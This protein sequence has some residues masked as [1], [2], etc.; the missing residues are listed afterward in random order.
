L[1]ASDSRE[2]SMLDLLFLGGGF[3]LL[4]LFIAYERLCNR[5]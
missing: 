3:L 1:Y 2:D 5:L 4:C